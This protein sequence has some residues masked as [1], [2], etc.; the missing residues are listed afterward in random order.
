MKSLKDHIRKDMEGLS[1]SLQDSRKTR[2]SF[3]WIYRIFNDIVASLEEIKNVKQ[4]GS[5]SKEKPTPTV[6]EGYVLISDWNSYP[7]HSFVSSY[8]L[9]HLFTSFHQLRKTAV[10]CGRTYAVNPEEVWIYFENC[11]E[12]MHKVIK[13]K[14]KKL[15]KSAGFRRSSEKV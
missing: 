9:K 3:A 8:T 14:Q 12:G 10:K 1:N 7:A 6:P 4:S 13:N 11:P 15:L 5:K 2:E